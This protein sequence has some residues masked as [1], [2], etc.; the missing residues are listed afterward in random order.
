LVRLP[1]LD[2]R[3]DVW[4]LAEAARRAGDVLR[5]PAIEGMCRAQPTFDGSTDLMSWVRANRYSLPHVVGTCAMGP[6]PD[7]GAV[8]DGNGAV[9]GVERLR[10]IDAS[11]MP[12][13][14]SGFP[15]LAT[16]MIA[17]KLAAQID[18]ESST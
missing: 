12:S 14:T 5:H 4:R 16:I 11:I 15:H 8:V 2:D 7:Q 10:V 3:E 9:H 1:A 13:A 18:A 17:E 6:M